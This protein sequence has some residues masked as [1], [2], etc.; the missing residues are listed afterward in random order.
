MYRG[1]RDDARRARAVSHVLL[2]PV[3]GV[4][5]SV[6]EVGRGDDGEDK[7][8]GRYVTFQLAGVA[9]P[10][11]LFVEILRLID[12]LRWSAPGLLRSCSGVGLPLLWAIAFWICS[13]GGRCCNHSRSVFAEA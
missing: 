4:E 11:T 10:G 12:G 9:I 5:A 3:A 13:E 2:R 7:R 1:A 8:H 6:P